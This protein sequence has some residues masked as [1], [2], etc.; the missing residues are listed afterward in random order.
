MD[1]PFQAEAVKAEI[2]EEDVIIKEEVFTIKEEEEIKP[3]L[4][5]VRPLQIEPV[6]RDSYQVEPTP[7]TSRAAVAEVRVYA[8]A[9]DFKYDPF[10]GVAIKSQSRKE[11][12]F[13]LRFFSHE[14][15]GL[16]LCDIFTKF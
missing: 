1:S 9:Q 11:A 5:T 10:H 7:S 6:V 16:H 3:D 13:Y 4:A 15:V 12:K 2:K 8:P 14:L